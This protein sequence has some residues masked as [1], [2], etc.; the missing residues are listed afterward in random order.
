MNQRWEITKT[1]LRLFEPMV[2]FSN[3]C[4]I[5]TTSQAKMDK[6][7][8]EPEEYT[9][10]VTRTKYIGLLNPENQLQANQ[11]KLDGIEEWPTPTTTKEV[12]SFLGFGNFDKEFIQNDEDLIKPQNRQN[13]NEQDNKDMVML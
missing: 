2:M 13:K 5:R 8:P 7:F 3:L 6:I 12:K 10:W 1:N 11:T 4:N 9:S